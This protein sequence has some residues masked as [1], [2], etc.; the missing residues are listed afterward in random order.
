MQYYDDRNIK[1]REA[2]LPLTF[3]RNDLISYAGPDQII[4]TALMLNMFRFALSKLT[5]GNELAERNK[6]KV[7]VGFPGPGIKDC[8]ELVLRGFTR[9]ADN[10]T[11][12]TEGLP[13]EAPLALVGRFYFEFEYNGR[14]I[15]LWP[16]NEIF[17]DEFRTMVSTFQP[18]KGTAEEQQ[19]FQKFKQ[20]FIAKVMNAGE[21]NLFHWK[22]LS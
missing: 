10:V 18:R 21:E 1:L 5:D 3:S 20:D 19:A 16:Q 7:Q 22:Q 6:I 8:I 11:I 12:K 14:R 9:N 4:A 15:G 17:N 13:E 2:D